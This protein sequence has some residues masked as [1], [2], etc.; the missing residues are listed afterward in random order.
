MIIRDMFAEDIN[1]KI[2]GV[3]KVDQAEDVV[4]ESELK[5]YVITKELKKHFI[6]FFNYYS[7]AF[8][9]PT[10]DMGVWISGFFGSGKSHFLKILSY[11]LSNREVNGIRTVERF[12]EKFADDPGTFMLI[13]KSVQGPTETILFNIDIEGPMEKDKTAVL[14]VFAKMFYNHLGFYGEDLKVA[15]LEQFIEHQGKT[16]EFRRA[17]AQQNGGEWLTSRD[18]FAFYEDD[19]VAVLQNVLGMSETAARN[20]FNGTETTEMSI[21]RLVAEIKEYVEQQPENY[22]LLFMADEVGQYIGT[23]RDMLL[24]FQ[25][26]TEKLGSECNG[27]VWIVATGQEAV[28]E[29]IKVRQ[30]EF[31]RIMARFKTR[32]S[33]SSSSVDEVIQRRVL[34][35]KPEAAELLLKQYDANESVLRNLFS[36]NTPISDIKGYKGA[37]EF[38]VDFPFVPYQFIL[39]QKV[40]YEI[41]KHG[42]TGKN[43]SGG[44]RS[45]LSG[46]Q[47]SVQAIENLDEISLVPFYRFYDT[48]NSFLDSSIRRVI[49]RCDKAAEDGNGIEKQDVPVL[50]L[51][52]LIRYIDKDMP[53]NLDNLVILMAD[54]INVDKIAMRRTIADSLNRLQKQN[55]IGRMGDT[56]NF[57]TDEEQD[58]QRDIRTTTV[59]TANIISGI[60]HII[61]GDIYTNKKYRY[62]VYDFAFDQMVDGVSVGAMTGG[63]CLKFITNAVD[64]DARSVLELTMQSKGRAIIVLSEESH[65]YESLEQAMKIR[66]YIKQKNITNLPASVQ[67]IIQAQSDEAGKLEKSVTEELRTAIEQAVFYVDGENLSIKSGDA[68]AKIDE[69]LEYLVTHVYSELDQITRHMESDAD[70]ANILR[71]AAHDGVIEGMEENRR[72]AMEIEKYLEMQFERHLPT[73]MADIQSRYSAIPYG[74]KEIDIAAVVAMLIYDQKVTIKYGGNT[75]QPDFPRLPE[76]LRK[77][78]EIGRTSISKRQVIAFSKLREIREF[79]RDYFDI[80]DVPEDE[81]GLV[82]F[83]IE[84]FSQQEAD[85]AQMEARYSGHTYPEHH[86]L[87]DARQLLQDVLQRQKDN[88]ALIDYVLQQEDALYRSK[89]G[90]QNLEEFF[91]QQVELFDEAVQFERELRQDLDYLRDD[92]AADQALNQIRLI[93]LV[94]ESEPYNYQRIP[95]L[96]ELLAQVRAVH[97]QL[98]DAKRKE[99]LEVIR[100]CMEAIHTLGGHEGPAKP[101]IAETDAFYTKKKK[102]LQEARSLRVL[103][104]FMNSLCRQKDAAC[105][106]IQALLRPKAEPKQKAPVHSVPV[107]GSEAEVHEPKAQPAKRQIKHIYRQAVFPAEYLATEA[108]VDAYVERLRQALKEAIKDTDGIR[109]N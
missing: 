31:S 61:Y 63:M 89:D 56:Y 22:R 34:A 68:K 91:G 37:R 108:D 95:E 99:N 47:E 7:D 13:D 6:S 43:L 80:M 77:K 72:A 101:I 45:M 29:I 19:I 71:G 65:Y 92:E 88:L 69:A 44:E 32:L 76:L 39:M 51:L 74:W 2:N 102:E 78:S 97:D 55:Y 11:L 52:Y 16:E 46:F 70:L 48:V 105:D 24:N 73:S 82:S 58:I 30:D 79:L 86:R 10:A 15:K 9:E 75:I 12:R 35:K 50:K 104:G 1:R 84:H 64:G 100:Q 98:L 109:L 5:E 107:A 90:L 3:V 67:K 94:Q 20:W 14:R 96:T 54:R 66:K 36:F 81:D 17:F 33:L 28:E 60:A 57:L 42:N 49:D 59:D 26:L 103:D 23:D 87:Q 62:G 8:D 38:T 27:K 85:Y 83:I 25:S 21:A 106:E 53:A 40:F 18:A 4:I 93:V 41:R